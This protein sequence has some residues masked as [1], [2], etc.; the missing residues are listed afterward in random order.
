[1]SKKS[2]SSPVSSESE[3]ISS[4]AP[5][6][7]SPATISQEE[8]TVDDLEEGAD[9]CTPESASPQSSKSSEKKLWKKLPIGYLI[10]LLILL[11][12]LGWLIDKK[13]NAP[14]EKPMRSLPSEKPVETYNYKLL[15]DS[16]ILLVNDS[17]ISVLSAEL[18]KVLTHEYTPAE[19]GL[20]DDD[21]TPV[22]DYSDY[23]STPV[24]PSTQSTSSNTLKLTTEQSVR[25]LLISN[26]FVNYSTSDVLT[27]SKNGNELLLNGE[28]LTVE[29]EVSKMGSD[30]ATLN[31]YDDNNTS[32]DVEL[33]LSGSTKSLRFMDATYVSD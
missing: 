9:D 3:M 13:V 1:M 19:L 27:F 22:D 28:P 4:N 17:V 33:D 11:L 18:P 29:M 14:E 2:K 12:I 5:T 24:V 16:S 31:Y 8:T 32:W 30:Q 10:F 15:P 7:K 6:E 20:M 21:P 25:N 23:A 26:R